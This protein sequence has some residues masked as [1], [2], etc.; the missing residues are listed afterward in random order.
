MKYEIIPERV[1][2]GEH[3]FIR[4]EWR[5]FYDINLV[6]IDYEPFD[7][8]GWEIRDAGL[9]GPVTILRVQ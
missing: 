1:P 9:L 5:R 6:N 8:S 7:A 4:V 3:P 2:P